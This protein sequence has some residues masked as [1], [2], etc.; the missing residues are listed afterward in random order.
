MSSATPAR[1]FPE[2]SVFK[3]DESY[4]HRLPVHG[5]EGYPTAECK[6]RLDLDSV[7]RDLQ[8]GPW[9][10]AAMDLA[11]DGGGLAGAVATSSCV[12]A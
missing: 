12:R 9:R 5:S 8:I 4:W 7:E 2:T 11:T 3:Q 1:M 6:C 10:R